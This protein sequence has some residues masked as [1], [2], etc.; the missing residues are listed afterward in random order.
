MGDPDKFRLTT[1]DPSM[2]NSGSGI[3]CERH[4]HDE[5]SDCY[6]AK[7]R[8][9]EAVPSEQECDKGYYSLTVG[10]LGEADYK[11][12]NGNSPCAICPADTYQEERG[13]NACKDCPAN[14]HT[15]DP[16][17]TY[18]GSGKCTAD[19]HDDK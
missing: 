9:S 5:E 13:Q 17:G 10:I 15:C 1:C 19:E 8:L 18:Q 3:G 6:K 7:K 4:E 14:T 16:D 12:A 11:E 2:T